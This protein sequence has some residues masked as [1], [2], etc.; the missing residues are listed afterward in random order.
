MPHMYILE[1]ADGTYYTGST[2]DL[3][4][5]VIEH[6]SGLGANFTAKRLPVKLVYWEE[7]LRIDEAFVREKQIQNWSQAKKKALI[8]GKFESLPAKAKKDFKRSTSGLD[9]PPASSF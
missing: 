9:T 8:E 2:R 7:F 1:C 4:R 6:N 5:R 3:E